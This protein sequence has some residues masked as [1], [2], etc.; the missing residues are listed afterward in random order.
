MRQEAQRFSETVRSGWRLLIAAWRERRTD[1]NHKRYEIDALVKLEGWSTA[2]VRSTMEMYRPALTAKA[3]FA[4]F[5]PPDEPDLPLERMVQA[6]VEYP[7]PHEPLTIPPEHLAY[8][9][10]IFRG[11]IEH[12]IALERETGGSDRIYFDTTRPDDGEEPDED[13]FQLTG[14][15][16]TFI[17]M[18]FRL[19]TTN[20]SAAK[21]EFDR[22]PAKGN[23]VFTRLR[24]WA[25]SQPAI[26]DGDQAA[27]V[28]QSLDEESFWTD[29]HERD[30]LFAL[31]DRWDD[32]SEAAQ[33]KLEQRLLTGSFPWP[34]PRD[35]L[36]A[37]N[38]H[39]RLNRL[40]WLSGRGVRFGFD[41]DA[42]IAEN[43]REAP[44]WQPRF[45]DRTAQ[46]N[47]GKV[48]TIVTETNPANL[49]GL[50]VGEILVAARDA[51]RLDFDSDVERRPFLGLAEERP[52]L[53]LAVITNAARRGEF[54]E[55]EWAALLHATSKGEQ[56]SRLLRTIAFRLSKLSIDQ[57][58]D[59][60]HPI[61][62][63]L[64]DRASS[65]FER[66]PDVVNVIWNLL[67][68]ALAKRPA[69]DR[70]RRTDAGWVD[71]A[72]NQPAGRMI[73]ALFKDPAKADFRPG[74][75]LP[76][77]WKTR[78]DQALGLPGDARRHA[79]AMISPHLNWLFNI[80]PEWSERQLLQLAGDRDADGEAF[81][82]G[83]FWAARTPQ[84]PLYLRL[85]PA[86][87]AL[88][89][90]GTRR[91]DQANKLAGMLLAGWA[92][93]G[94]APDAT[95][96]IPDV[97]LRE[98]LIYADDDLRTQM[99]WYL[100]RWS[101]EP[102]SNWG[103]QIIPF[104][105]NVWPRQS[106]VKNP[107]TSGRLVDLALG[108]PHRFPEIV[109]AILPRLGP[110][111]GASVRI[112]P[113]LDI[114]EGIAATHPRHLLDLL[115]AVLPEDPWTWPYET[116]R[117]LDALAEQDTVRDDSRLAELRRRA[118]QR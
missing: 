47:V 70:F 19:A 73:D 17:N 75:G 57:A 96:L 54:A 72:L 66:L 18:M 38:A 82:G 87:V 74:G 91:R 1:P 104:L 9:I 10:S 117:A 29:Q 39:Y 68:A 78:L 21:A 37:V 92:G 97:E 100:Q 95:A 16:A 110:I 49:S 53:A 90:A 55:R 51:A 61:S 50:P 109:E 23:Q 84:L 40:Q 81:W 44:E 113:F 20:P 115:W 59:L 89:H 102:D 116:G 28:F 77:I 15:L 11:Q 64:R 3:P 101:N 71:D 103:E 45:A 76:A 42:A 12:A 48:R 106:A 7:R 63:W 56:R 111:A 65:L 60:R 4:T 88:A 93:D 36:A 31:R 24:I 118:E 14:L 8:A 107:R 58:A 67:A 43:R 34:E 32:M 108:M 80:D 46:P 86:F 79:I 2:L 22:W 99:L 112:G 13:G 30:L 52:S 33:H 94:E 25:A 5:A 26:L 114:E 27:E 105:R 62:E 6:D 85:K 98:I 35:D 83:Y 69:P 41:I